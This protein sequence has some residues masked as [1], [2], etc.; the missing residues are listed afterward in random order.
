MVE[1]DSLGQSTN[2]EVYFEDKILDGQAISQ[3]QV[4]SLDAFDNIAVFFD[5][6]GRIMPYELQFAS[7]K[8][9]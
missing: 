8:N 5:V 6:S 9:K 1:S 7:N 3:K 4:V 2:R